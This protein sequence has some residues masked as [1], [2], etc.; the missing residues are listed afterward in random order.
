VVSTNQEEME[1]GF[2]AAWSAVSL[3][4]RNLTEELTSKRRVASI[5]CQKFAR[6]RTSFAPSKDQVRSG[7]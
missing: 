6:L 7:Y 3:E 5:N 4:A 2:V 1:Q